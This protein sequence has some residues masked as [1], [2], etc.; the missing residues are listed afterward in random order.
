MPVVLPK[1]KVLLN[2]LY[3]NPSM[4]PADVEKL[5]DVAPATANSVIQDLVSLDILREVTGGMLRRKGGHCMS[6]KLNGQKSGFLKRYFE[7]WFVMDCGVS[8]L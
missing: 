4:T 5:L 6:S 1:A 7:Q 3:S 8:S 2:A